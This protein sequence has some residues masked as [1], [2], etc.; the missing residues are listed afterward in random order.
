[1]RGVRSSRCSRHPATL[2]DYNN[3]Q[4][5]RGPVAAHVQ[6]CPQVWTRIIRFVVE[7]DICLQI[8]TKLLEIDGENIFV[9]C[10]RNKLREMSREIPRLVYNGE[11]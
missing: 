6:S 11:R 1:M 5:S 2:P 10:F 8:I 3:D 7:L 4:S 9:I